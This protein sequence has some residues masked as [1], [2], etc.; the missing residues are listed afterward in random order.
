[1]HE[2]KGSFQLLCV[3][4]TQSAVSVQESLMASAVSTWSSGDQFAFW[5]DPE[6]RAGCQKIRAI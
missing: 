4:P 6:K 3:I 1:M 2:Q 5:G